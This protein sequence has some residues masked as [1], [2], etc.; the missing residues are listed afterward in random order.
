MRDSDKFVLESMEGP[1][2]VKMKLI[3]YFV[4]KDGSRKSEMLTETNFFML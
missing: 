3:T 1:D 2:A 4:G